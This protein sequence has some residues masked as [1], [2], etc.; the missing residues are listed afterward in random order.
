MSADART[1]YYR[2][3]PG[4]HPGWRIVTTQRHGSEPEYARVANEALD[5][6]AWWPMS[7]LIA[8]EPLAG[9]AAVA[10]GAEAERKPPVVPPAAT[11]APA[12]AADRKEAGGVIAAPPAA[13]API[14]GARNTDPDTAHDAALSVA[15]A[16]KRKVYDH[17]LALMFEHGPLTDWQLAEK[18]SARMGERIIATSA[19]VRR[20]ELRNMGLVADTGHRGPTET[21]PKKG[22]RWG[23]TAAGEQQVAA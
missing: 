15:D 9:F 12:V 6:W 14:K 1:R 23:L 22:I 18:L 17:I 19:G 10:G 13:G 5:T 21:G 2:I 7:Q 8:V 4:G 20:G 16:H 11:I 3:T